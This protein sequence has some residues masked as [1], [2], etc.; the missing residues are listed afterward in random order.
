MG[1]VADWRSVRADSA[2]FGGDAMKK[3]LA[4]QV[5]RDSLGVIYSQVCNK[6][7]TTPRI[8]DGVTIDRAN[9][10]GPVDNKTVIVR[11]KLLATLLGIPYEE[12]LS[13][14][15]KRK[16]KLKCLCPECVKDGYA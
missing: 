15:C 9:R 7:N 13:W 4:V 14:Q 2:G 16:D 10:R 8:L 1:V 3:D 11:A 6:A 12:D 5:Y